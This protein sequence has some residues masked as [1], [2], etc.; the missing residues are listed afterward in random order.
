MH[1]MWT[2]NDACV[3]LHGP[4]MSPPLDSRLTYEY[5]LYTIH[6]PWKPYIL[7]GGCVFVVHR[8]HGPD[9]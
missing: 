8:S 9:L 2:E 5:T 6:C 3:D 4:D 7:T 1:S